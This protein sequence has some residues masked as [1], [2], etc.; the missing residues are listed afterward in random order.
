[1][2]DEINNWGINRSM[3][4]KGKSYKNNPGI[5]NKE[6]IK[7]TNKSENWVSK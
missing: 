6:M 2:F 7:I 3:R 5:T 1:M 4:F